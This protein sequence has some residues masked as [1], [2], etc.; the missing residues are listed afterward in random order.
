MLDAMKCC[1]G[2]Q[3]D[4]SLVAFGVDR[5]AS[6]GRTTRCRECRAAKT[7]AWTAANPGYAS[8]WQKSNPKRVAVYNAEA[9]AK[10]PSWHLTYPETAA[11][12]NQRRRA[13]LRGAQGHASPEQIAGRV[14]YYGG[15]C[16]LCSDPYDALDHIKPLS[17]GGSNWPS[18]LRPICTPCNLAKGAK[19]P[20]PKE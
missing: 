12:M 18:N 15:K 11:A 6:D 4:L 8:A 13:R 16:W 14:A 19:W 10:R 2:C 9:R 5:H 7:R 1:R 20:F 3:R 17:R